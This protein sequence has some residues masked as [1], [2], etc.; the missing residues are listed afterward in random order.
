MLMQL[1][2]YRPAHPKGRA[3]LLYQAPV[4]W[5]MIGSVQRTWNQQAGLALAD[6]PVWADA[7]LVTLQRP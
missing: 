1:P 2:S 7:A 3:N 6:V 5:C 4:G